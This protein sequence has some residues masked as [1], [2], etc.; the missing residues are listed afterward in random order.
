MR[1]DLAEPW[2]RG[3]TSGPLVLKVGQLGQG[4]VAVLDYSDHAVWKTPCWRYG[5]APHTICLTPFVEDD[6]LFYDYYYGPVIRTALWASR[7]EPD[8]R[9]S[10]GPKPGLT[11]ARSALPGRP[12]RIRLRAHKDA[13][14]PYALTWSVR[15]RQG[16]ATPL[17]EQ[18]VAIGPS[19]D[20]SVEMPVC[21]AGLHMVDLW[22]KEPG[23]KKVVTWAS[24]AVRVRAG[25]T[26]TRVEPD[27]PFFMPGDKVTGQVVLSKALPKG[28]TVTV[29]LVDS[30]DRVVDRRKATGSGPVLGVTFGHPNSR[31]RHYRLVARLT[32]GRGLVDRAEASFGVPKDA[33]PE[34]S[35]AMWAPGL[36]NHTW[37]TIRR[38][39]YRLGVRTLY[40]TGAVWGPEPVYRTS[41][42]SLARENLRA[43]PY[44]HGFW[45]WT[46]KGT[47][48]R[49][50]STRKMYV[51]K[52]GAYRRYGI[53]SYSIGEESYIKHDLKEWKIPEAL[54]DFRAYLK[55]RYASVGKLNAVW[56]TSYKT[57]DEPEPIDLPGALATG[58]VPQWLDH[59]LHK[60]DAFMRMHELVI[61]TIHKV[62]PGARISIDCIAG[63]R[64]WDWARLL[65][66]FGGLSP[67]GLDVFQSVAQ[68]F[69]PP[70]PCGGTW[71]GNYPWDYSEDT[72]R[73]IPW[74]DLLSGQANSM[75][76][77]CGFYH[78]LGGAAAFTPDVVP[79][80]CMQQTSEEIREINRGA[81]KLIWSAEKQTY[82]IAVHYSKPCYFAGMVSN[83]ETMWNTALAD[84]MHAVLDLG[85]GARCVTPADVV[86]GDLQRQ[87]FK[88]LILPY[89]QAMS[90]AE[91]GAVKAFVHAGGILLADF[92][93]A[94]MDEH[95]RWRGPSGVTKV[96]ASDVA[97]AP[98]CPKCKGKGRI[99][100]KDTGGTWTTCPKCGGTGKRIRAAA[101][102]IKHSALAELF[103]PWKPLAVRPYGQGK[104]V[105]V[106]DRLREYSAKRRALKGAGNRRG[107]G[108]LLSQLAGIRPAV[109][110]LNVAGEDRGDT[111]ITVF[112][113]GQARYVGLVRDRQVRA[114][115][116]GPETTVVL[117]RPCHVYDVRQH[118]YLGHAARFKTGLLAARAK[119]FGLLPV[120]LRT[121]EVRVDRQTVRPGGTVA[122]GVSVRPSA[123]GVGLAFHVEVTGPDGKTIDYYT[124]NVVMRD[125]LATHA[126]PIA[127][128]AAPGSHRVTI[129]EVV[130]GLSEH[131]TFTVAAPGPAK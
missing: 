14:G 6:P 77:P 106:G 86:K 60:I 22:V 56:G 10:A 48:N 34:Y 18:K 108:E 122:V 125:G 4:R 105:Y 62:H 80:A 31:S 43:Y 124:E 8:V 19:T 17:G 41:A 35:L 83:A 52:A 30:Y 101:P 75:W 59:E 33:I 76:W 55:G 120:R 11:V 114:G 25:T 13:A 64:N 107:L 58:R 12:V 89:S 65:R 49:R 117:D 88:V 50:E 39:L 128:N 95:L 54:K 116:A 42:E 57:W 127:L 9:I 32:D 92:P 119:L 2:H 130:S 123:K 36:N 47:E 93:P 27:K 24:V 46:M 110:V 84:W 68:S 112:T 23:S 79:L 3:G 1:K 53:T 29:D 109:R 90:D 26:I 104:A 85:L 51:S 66:Q 61:R 126:L 103:K 121:L 28:M 15:D 74:H 20:V 45:D 72:Q 115:A 118:Q 38:E 69:L 113:L 78:G 7:R 21:G 96:A 131:A 97:N 111:N 81:G 82:P 70:K 44:C 67:G 91:V 87:A 129:E 71:F 94:V 37:R 40:D 5:C 100:V 98:T 99:E 16:K 102:K 63:E 73:F